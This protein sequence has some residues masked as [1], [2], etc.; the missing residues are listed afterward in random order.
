MVTDHGDRIERAMKLKL[1]LKRDRAEPRK[2]TYEVFAV[3]TITKSISVVSAYNEEDAVSYANRRLAANND[4]VKITCADSD[5]ARVE[6]IYA[7][8]RK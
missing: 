8:E 4:C 1:E 3:I 7:E 2:K 5:I 6:H